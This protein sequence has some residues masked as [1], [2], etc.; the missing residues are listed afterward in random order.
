M[1]V[2]IYIMCIMCMLVAV[3]YV[4]CLCDGGAKTVV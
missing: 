3:I 1:Y 4:K 2:Y